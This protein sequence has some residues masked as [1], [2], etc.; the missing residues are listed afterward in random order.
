MS[1]DHPDLV[2]IIFQEISKGG[3]IPFARF[4]E[5]ALYEP[6]WGYYT[7]ID[8][9][10]ERIGWRGDF[11]T[12]SD[13]SGL[14]AHTI[15]KQILE[16]D[17]LLA[18]PNPLTFVE[19]GPG[20][21]LFFKEFLASCQTMNGSVLSRLKYVLVERSPAFR[22]IQ[23]ALE[24][25]GTIGPDQVQWVQSLSQLD[26][27]SLTGVFFS[28]ELV[29]AFP[30][31]RVT[32][33]NGYLQEIFVGLEAGVLT[34]RPLPLSTRDLLTYLEQAQVQLS[35]N[36]VVEVNLQA[37]TWIQEVARVLHRG[38]VLTMDYGHPAHDLYGPERQTGT[39][40]GYYRHT[41]IDNPYMNIGNQDLTAHV[42]FTALARTG[43]KAGLQLTGFTN[44]MSFLMGLGIDHT[45]QALDQE[46][47]EFHN[48]S[49]LV[50]PQGMGQTFKVLI[51]HKGIAE[52]KVQ[53][54]RYQPFFQ[55]SLTA[56]P[57]GAP[58]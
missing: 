16:I 30:V 38:M 50:R 53:G 5:L 37:Q 17:E 44:Y 42:N 24:L 31:H 48:A 40:L 47:P 32:M 11:Y 26:T 33:T 27:D 20:N 23:Q 55:S 56:V 9:P 18:H 14:F 43:E 49:Q 35:E 41:V 54:L 28:N 3:P 1:N 45:L 2:K 46:S 29:D 6:S 19:M 21:G 15:T 36:Q 7:R 57:V 13:V 34:E 58:S 22:T 52:P 8:P 25:P 51:Q 12:S 10:A 39:L 4:M